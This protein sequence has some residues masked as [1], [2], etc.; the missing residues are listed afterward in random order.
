LHRTRTFRWS[1]L[2]LAALALIYAAASI[3]IASR[4]LSAEVTPLAAHPAEQRLIYEEVEFPPR[5]WPELR[6]R[7]WWL[8]AAEPRATVIR[9]H[10][11]DSN[12]SSMLG[13]SAVLVRS[14][15]SVLVFDLRGHGESDAARMGAGLDE[16]DDVFG[17]IDFVRRRSDAGGGSVFLHGSSYGGAIALMAGWREE[18]VVGVFAD[19][20][21]AALRELVTQE[22]ASRTGLPRWVAVGLRPG[23]TL[24]GRLLHGVDID[25]VNPA[26]EAA[27]YA[28]PLGLA[29][30]RS[31][32]RIPLDHF[33]QIES[34]VRLT[35]S[36]RVFHDCP[37]ADAW[38][39][40]PIEYA[41]LVTEY[42]SSRLN[43]G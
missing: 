11:I 20:S 33:E 16:R 31:D 40:Y 14:G 43:A 18:V 3:Y 34:S 41:Q 4:S 26:A 29:H 24:S 23:I 13:L 25:A 1:L 9:V 5:G 15:Y 17:A 10:G 35:P 8:P 2:V 21:F 12:R 22:V 30:C 36:A 38:D 6:L 19:S 37:H 42:F 28:Y 39:L 7:G 32:E 27:E